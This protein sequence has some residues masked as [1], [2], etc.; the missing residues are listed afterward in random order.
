MEAYDLPKWGE[1]VELPFPVQA[2]FVHSNQ[3]NYQISSMYRRQAT[4][5]EPTE[6]ERK[7]AFNYFPTVCISVEATTPAKGITQYRLF[8]SYDVMPAPL[9]PRFVYEWPLSVWQ[10][11][12]SEHDK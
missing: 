8:P 5:D 10:G 6:E 12:Y 1:T 9:E 3:T 7:A 4:S 2:N 11:H